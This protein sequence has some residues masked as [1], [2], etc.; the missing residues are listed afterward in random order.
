MKL[1]KLRN[2]RFGRI[3]DFLIIASAMLILMSA[4]FLGYKVGVTSNATAYT[5]LTPES[6]AASLKAQ[7]NITNLTSAQIQQA[8]KTMPKHRINES[9][10]KVYPTGV[11]ID[12]KNPEWSTFTPTKSMV[13]FLDQGSYAIQIVPQSPSDLQ[14]GDIIS[15]QYGSDII[16][17]RIIRTGN[18]SEGW[19][20]IVKGDNNNQPDP[21]KVRFSQ[22]KRVLVAIIY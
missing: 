7:Q 12:V 13:P 18:D 9:Q 14:I 4:F 22:V 17:H 20:A 8:L 11:Q 6:A 15:Y 2:V 19:Y 3:Y 21:F 10:I 1:K 5:T 16:I